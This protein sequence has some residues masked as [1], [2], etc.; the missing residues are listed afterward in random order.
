M[1]TQLKNKTKQNLAL[2]IC[3]S[4]PSL[5]KTHLHTPLCEKFAAFIIYIFD[6][7]VIH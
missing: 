4:Y 3:M 7:Y 6:H 2:K 5:I 1:E